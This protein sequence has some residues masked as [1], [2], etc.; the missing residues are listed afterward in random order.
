MENKKRFEIPEAIIVAFNEEDI[1]VTSTNGDV[2]AW[3]G[4]HGDEYQD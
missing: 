1:I 4:Q 3:W 2:G